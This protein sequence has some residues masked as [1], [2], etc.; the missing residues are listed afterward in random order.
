VARGVSVSESRGKRFGPLAA[1]GL[2][3]FAKPFLETKVLKKRK[4]KKEKK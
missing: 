2:F 4:K 1:S 3:Y